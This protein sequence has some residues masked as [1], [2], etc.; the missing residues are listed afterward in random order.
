MT[1][2]NKRAKLYHTD[3]LLKSVM[4]KVCEPQI[5]HRIYIDITINREMF[6]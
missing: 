5:V 4:R 3:G 6:V 1:H 2:S